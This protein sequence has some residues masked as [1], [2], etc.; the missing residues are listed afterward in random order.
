MAEKSY[1]ALGALRSAIVLRGVT[2]VHDYSWGLP[3]RSSAA[4]AA[5]T[6]KSGAENSRSDPPY[7]P[8]GVRVALRIKTAFIAARRC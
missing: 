7:F 3:A 1:L 8:I 6:P 5:S 4:R 2:V